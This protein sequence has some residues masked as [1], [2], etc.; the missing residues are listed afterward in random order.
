M[1]LSKDAYQRI[2]NSIKK[3]ENKYEVGGVLLGHRIIN[4]YFVVAVTVPT[5]CDT[6]SMVSF[7][8]D[9]KEHTEHVQRIIQ[10]FRIKPSVLGVWHSHI[11]DIAAFSEQDRQSN[12]R[13]AAV[14]GGTLSMIVS[15]PE[16]DKRLNLVSCHI[17]AK[18]KE[19]YCNTTT[20]L[21]GRKIPQCCTE[22]TK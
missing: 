13:L 12:R 6:R 18:G 1:I 20:D 9:G 7:V 16:P 10:N 2:K 5:R 8:L 22:R 14:L 19:H 17:T 4:L 15:M 3:A 11:C 21:A